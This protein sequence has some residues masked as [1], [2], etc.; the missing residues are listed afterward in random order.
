MNKN[1]DPLDTTVRVITP[2]NIAF[3]YRIAGPMRR[4]LAYAIDVVICFVVGIAALFVVSVMSVGIPA[5]DDFLLAGLLLLFFFLSWF[6]GGLLETFWNGQTVGKRLVGL[7]V[8]TFQGEPINGMQAIMRN[9][10]RYVDG[11]PPFW[12]PLLPELMVYIPIPTFLAGIIACSVNR[13]AQ[14]LGDLAC[15]TIVV[16]EERVWRHGIVKITNAEVLALAAELPAGLEVSKPLGQALSDYVQRR[17][18]FSPL[19]RAEIARHVGEPLRIR[20][21]LPEDTSYDHLLSALYYR[22]FIT[23]LTDA[24]AAEHAVA[25]SSEGAANIVV[26]AQVSPPAR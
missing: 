12:I 4:G 25:P 9:L 14:R 8:L 26:D 24:P 22:T 11:F 5:V 3:R 21:Q 7:R 10:L 18:L 19:R 16:I 23:D 15:G 2:E 6:Y 20:F 1:N 13:R 17:S